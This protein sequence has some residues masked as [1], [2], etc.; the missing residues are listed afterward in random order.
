MPFVT[1]Q[2]SVFLSGLAQTIQNMAQA[3]D[4]NN[5][6]T[7]YFENP[8]KVHHCIKWLWFIS[9]T[10]TCMFWWS[11]GISSGQVHHWRTQRH[12]ES[13]TRWNSGLRDH[14]H[15]LCDSCRQGQRSSHFF[16]YTFQVAPVTFY[17]LSP[18][19]PCVWKTIQ[20]METINSILKLLL[21]MIWICDV[22]NSS[23]LSILQSCC[24]SP[25]D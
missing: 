11:S 13:E 1:S 23:S 6:V 16:T 4:D 21:T 20:T 12:P 10:L 3:E 17:G 24:L 8:G 14:A 18:T 19:V 9:V 15:T 22:L 5:L 7:L 2:E 25:H